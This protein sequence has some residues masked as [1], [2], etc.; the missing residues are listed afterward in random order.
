MRQIQVRQDDMF[1]FLQVVILTY[2]DRILYAS[3]E[4]TVEDEDTIAWE[5]T[6]PPDDDRNADAIYACVS[7]LGGII[8]SGELLDR[9]I[10]GLNGIWLINHPDSDKRS[11]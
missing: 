3:A 10:E 1:P 4:R 6:L 8:A 11:S 2:G 9:V 7:V 5:L